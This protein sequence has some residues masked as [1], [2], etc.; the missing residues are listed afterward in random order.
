MCHQGVYLVSVGSDWLF[1]YSGQSKVK[2]RYLRRH[3]GVQ[4]SPLGVQMR[5]LGVQM[6]HLGVQMRN[7]GAQMR[8]LGAQIRH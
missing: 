1:E 2:R 3:L 4:M 6:R 7:L 8:H 5:H